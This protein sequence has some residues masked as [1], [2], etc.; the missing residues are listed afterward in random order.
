M[1]GIAGI[2]RLDGAPVDRRVLERMTRTLAHRGPDGEDIW[3]DAFV[4]L[5]HRRLAIRDLSPDAAQPMSDPGGRVWVTFNGEIY[6]DRTLRAELERDFGFRFRT[7]CDTEVIP[8]GYIAWGDALFD[9][10]EGMFAIAIWDTQEKRLVLARDGIGI[11]PLFYAFDATA[12]R[13]G[14]E[15]KS[16]LA[17]PDQPRDLDA[18][19]VHR[20]LAL[21]HVGPTESMIRGIRQ[22][23]PGSVVSFRAGDVRTDTFWRPER[24]P[25]LR[26]LDEAVD[27]FMPIWD[28][29]IGDQLVSDVSVGVLQSGGVDSSLV[30]QSVARHGR[31]PLFTASFDDPSYDETRIA[32]Q[33]AQWTGLPH[34]PI[35]I[36]ADEAPGATLAAVVHHFDGQVADE[37]A[38]PLLLLTRSL[39]QHSTV[40]LSGDGGD[41]FFGGYLTYRVSSVAARWGRFLPTR[42]AAALGR[43]A[44]AIGAQDETRLPALTLLSRFLSGIAAGAHYAH[45]EW[46]RYLPAFLMPDVYGPALR[47]LI[48]QSP[49]SGYREAIDDAAGDT[50]LERCIVADQSYRLPGGLLMKTD[51]MSMANSV[52]LRVPLLDRRVMEFSARCS[53]DLL[54][55]GHGATKPLLRRAL[56]RRGAPLDVVEGP[57]RGFNAPLASL[58]RG[59]LHEICDETF[60]RSPELL[61]PYLEPGGVRQLWRE[62]EA[63]RRNHAYALWPMLT[64]GLWRSQLSGGRREFVAQRTSDPA[65]SL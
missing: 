42:L 58:M 39:K 45:A 62:H 24:Q 38:A 9:R 55:P 64:L 47:P 61:G 5:G 48:G 35:P 23:P 18:E 53:I 40:A 16:L 8:A 43:R 4:G 17:D 19:V 30:S 1:C 2:L 14:S 7:H 52:E 41:E 50:L 20:F 27:A 36:S 65:I 6:N 29:V 59:P 49:L 44:Y 56:K 12:V 37:S 33:V 31:F 28:R 60:E 25:V 51:A 15:I 21:G 54:V 11:K 26:D 34:K 13:F 3:V 57:K 22:V 63:R 10:L 46:R 32:A